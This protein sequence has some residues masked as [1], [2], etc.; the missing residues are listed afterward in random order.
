[1]KRSLSFGFLLLRDSIDNKVRAPLLTDYKMGTE[2]VGTLTHAD[3]PQRG[4]A[5]HSAPYP[6]CVYHALQ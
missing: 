3:A 4:N 2:L 5:S 6:V 1:M